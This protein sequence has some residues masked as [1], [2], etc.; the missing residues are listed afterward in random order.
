MPQDQ[1]ANA[2]GSPAKDDSLTEA[3]IIGLYPE[4]AQDEIQPED[5]ET[6]SE[7]ETEDEETE[8]QS[9]ETETEEEAEE[10]E[11]EETSNELDLDS[12]TP[13]QLKEWGRKAGSKAIT[14]YGKLTA[15]IHALEAKLQESAQ[16]QPE[17]DPFQK[18]TKV[19]NPQIAAIQ[20]IEDL[21]KWRD[22]AEQTEEWAQNLL[23]T[24]G[25]NDAEDVIATVK[26]KN[27]TKA[28]IL[29]IRNGAR[30][31]LK[32]DIPARL[33]ELQEID[34]AKR[35]KEHNAAQ[36][37]V[38]VPEAEKDE[39]VK[40]TFEG[41][42]VHPF[43]KAALADPKVAAVADL[44]LA[45]AARSMVQTAKKAKAPAIP[46]GKPPKAKPPGT[47]SGGGAPPPAF[48]AGTKGKELAKQEADFDGDPE[49]LV[50]LL[51]ARQS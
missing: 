8:E 16:R 20:S 3:D 32:N 13:D 45:H 9:E 15:K 21:G 11:A 27:Y 40:A 12:L 17:P 34:G 19:E 7:E 43:L 1:N 6:E 35:L 29:G 31:A 46:T 49:A 18:Q 22:E 5:H 30:K 51:H 36:V 24:Y 26:D 38:Q 14:R 10:E 42:K 23:D 47:P 39:E 28:Q 37:A 41:L 25:A 4:T 33:T 44:V 2:G 50:R 48:K